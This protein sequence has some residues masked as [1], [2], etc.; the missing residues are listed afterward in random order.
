[1][2]KTENIEVGDNVSIFHIRTSPIENELRKY[3]GLEGKLIKKFKNTFD[4]DVFVVDFG[5]LSDIYPLGNQVHFLHGEI[6]SLEVSNKMSHGLIK[7]QFSKII[8][9]NNWLPTQIN[10]EG[11]YGS[12]GILKF[13]RYKE[14]IIG[15]DEFTD[16]IVVDNSYDDF[17]KV[18]VGL[19]K[20][21]DTISELEWKK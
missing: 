20:H 21:K 7:I 3:L 10:G 9:K 15:I 8:N 13:F 2:N 5:E 4:N 6:E 17:M 11:D 1:M 12:G 16:E 19:K 14:R 18:L